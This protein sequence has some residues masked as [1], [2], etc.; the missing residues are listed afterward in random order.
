MPKSYPPFLSSLSSPTQTL[1]PHLNSEFHIN[2]ISFCRGSFLSLHFLDYGEWEIWHN[3][4]ARA[5][6]ICDD[7]LNDDGMQLMRLFWK[8]NF[9]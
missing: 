9:Y 6:E 3:V 7:G 1:T 5:G 8:G 4:L 2:I